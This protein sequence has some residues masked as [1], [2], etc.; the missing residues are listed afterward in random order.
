M[1]SSN[2]L[3]KSDENSGWA[4][5]KSSTRQTQSSQNTPDIVNDDKVLDG[6]DSSDYIHILE[7][8]LPTEEQILTDHNYD[9]SR[10][11]RKT[12]E[13]WTHWLPDSFLSMLSLLSLMTWNIVLMEIVTL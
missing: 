9:V 6:G 3:I 11:C 13:T 10:K 4:V 1:I 2:A 5:F 7:E 12:L 8:R